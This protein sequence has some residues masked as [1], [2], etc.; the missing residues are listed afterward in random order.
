MQNSKIDNKKKEKKLK[1]QIF[2]NIWQN[3][4]FFFPKFL[5]LKKKKKCS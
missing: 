4:I 1:F 5:K 3:F 2:K